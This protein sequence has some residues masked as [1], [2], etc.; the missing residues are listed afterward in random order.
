MAV[1]MLQGSAEAHW[2]MMQYASGILGN[3]VS[4]D[5]ED[6]KLKEAGAIRSV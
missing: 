6:L 5:V 4:A 3:F 2:Y 1:L